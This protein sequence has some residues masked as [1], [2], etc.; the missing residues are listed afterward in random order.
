[1][2][3][4]LSKDFAKSLQKL[5]G[6]ELRS[7]LAVIDEVEAADSVEKITDCKKLVNYNNVYR[8]R[9]GNKRAFFTLHIE[10]TNDKVI[11]HFLVSRGQAYTKAM[12][13]ELRRIDS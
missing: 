7:V 13:K 9:I 1:M 11:F 10:I 5:N 12:N 4:I 6:K 3:Y 2:K 8:I